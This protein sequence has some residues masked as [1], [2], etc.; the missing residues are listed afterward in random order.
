MPRGLL[1]LVEFDENG[2]PPDRVWISRLHRHKHLSASIQPVPEGRISETQV[3]PAEF[4]SGE[5][6]AVGGQYMRK[7]AVVFAGVD[8]NQIS[9]F[10]GLGNFTADFFL[11]LRYPPF[12]GL[13]PNDVKQIELVEIATGQEWS[14][15]ETPIKSRVEDGLR[16]ELY[17]VKADF[18]NAFDFHDY[19]F[20]TQTI[21][22]SLRN[23]SLTRDRLI[24]VVDEAG[25]GDAT[26]A[27]RP[28]NLG[29]VFRPGGTWSIG[30]VSLYESEI[31]N[32][33]TLSDPDASAASGL[34]YSQLY[35][36]IEI[37]R[38]VA[39]FLA[40]KFLP[41]LILMTLAYLVFYMPSDS[42]A[43]INGTLSGTL[44][45]VALFHFGLTTD[46]PGVGY[47]VALDFAFYVIYMILVATLLVALVAWRREEDER[48][49]HRLLLTAGTGTRRYS[50]SARSP[51]C[52]CT[53]SGRDRPPAPNPL[54]T[55]KSAAPRRTPRSASRRPMRVAHP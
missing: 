43:T 47:A 8:F 28:T 55:R 25:I 50:P 16:Y 33:S 23:R 49:V 6:L 52:S 36:V 45:A 41:V 17:R 4:E 46:L 14:L 48:L 31:R 32:I 7:A 15:P 5:L 53:T 39:G 10:D 13:D 9:N 44:V 19:P 1:G 26:T 30:G 12:E 35:A 11:W 38:N 51:S 54:Q 29:Q 27:L 20:D 22:I 42:F 3:L 24:Y 34:E 37:Q 40:K 2:D 18:S 21:R